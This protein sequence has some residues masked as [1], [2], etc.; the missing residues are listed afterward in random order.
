MKKT[1][2]QRFSEKVDM[3]G[4]VILDAPC[5]LYTGS[6]TKDGYGNIYKNLKH[7]YAHRYAYERVNGPIPAKAIVCHKCDN[8]PCVRPDHLFIGDNF[9]NRQDSL[10]K[11]R[12]SLA[13]LKVAEVIKIRELFKCGTKRRALAAMFN[14]SYHTI[15]NVISG[16]TWRNLTKNMSKE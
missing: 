15:N 14:V 13:K 7:Y 16:R 12:H 8:P 2:E 9:I 3:N 6:K 10:R 1:L 4:P 5:W 11:D